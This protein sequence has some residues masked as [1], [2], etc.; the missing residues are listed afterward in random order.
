MQ[1]T[2][3]LAGFVAAHA[4]LRVSEGKSLTM[5]LLVVEKEDASTQFIQVTGKSSEDAVK[6]GEALMK[7]PVPGARRAVLAFEAFLNLPPGRTDAIFLHACCF[8]PESQELYV[9]VPFRPA[10]DPG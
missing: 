6:K 8:Q 2:A 4:I 9:A 7:K 10:N 3:R 5:P 1:E